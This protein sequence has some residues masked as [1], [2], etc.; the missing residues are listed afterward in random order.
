VTVLEE[1]LYWDLFEA[2]GG[3]GTM[4]VWAE[5]TPKL[6]SSDLVHFTPKGAR[7]IGE[8]LDESLRAEYR[9]WEQIIGGE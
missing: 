7:L 5:S 2:M 9:S 6:A 4:E 1:A 8:L 3:A